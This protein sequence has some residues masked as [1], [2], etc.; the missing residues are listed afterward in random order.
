MKIKSRFMVALCALSLCSVMTLSAQNLKERGE[1][2]RGYKAYVD[3]EY[4]AAAEHFG[5]ALE[6]A[7]ESFEARF[8]LGSAL[9]KGE[10]Y[11]EAEKLLADLSADSLLQDSDRAQAY[12]NLGNS[13]FAQQ[14]LEEALE[15]YKSSMRLDPEDMEAKYNYAYTKAM[16]DQQQQNEDQN[17]DQN[18]DQENQDQNQDQQ[19]QDQEKQDQGDQEDQNQD[20]EQQDQEQNQDQGDQDKEDQQDQGGE[21]QPE[22]GQISEQEQQQ[23]LDAIQAQEDKTQDD[24]KEKA[25]GIVVPGAKNW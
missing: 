21:P 23:M 19:N 7:P 16:L 3:E 18:Q 1:V 20:Q 17:Q 24:L 25:R 8:N 12:Y 9:F 10:K 22:E 6:H 4:D 15:S 13:Q 14:K 11:E 5:K 2:R